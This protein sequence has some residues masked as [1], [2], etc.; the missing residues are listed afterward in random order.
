MQLS[1][2]TAVSP[3]DGRYGGKTSALRPIFS[4][5]GL[6]RCRVQVEVRWLQR[7]AAHAGIPEVA[8]FSDEANALLDQ[9]AENFQLEHAERVKEFE[10]TTNHDVKAVEYLLKEQ[11]KQLPELAK[12]NEFIHFAC[13]SEDINNLSHALMLR[14]GRD[15]VLLPLM[16]QLADAIRAL[17][18]AYAD[19]PMLSRTHGQ[20]ASPTTLGKELANVVYRLERQI[21]QVAAVPLLGK[22]NG[23]VGNYNAHLSAYPNVDWEANAREFIEG[24][25]GLSWNPYTT[26]IEPHDYIAELFDAV[27]RFNTILIDFDRDIWGYISLG[28]FKQRTVA[29]EIG[30]STMPHKVNPIDF[31][32][33]E[34]NLGIANAL[35]SHLAS[36]LPISRWQRDLTDSTVLRNL[37]V[38]FAHSIIAYE[39]S[40]KG[41]GKLEL[42]E[43]RIA[44]DLDACWEVLA[45]PIQTVMRR[46][47]IENPYEKLKEL[48]RGK[49]IS[50]EAL[51]TFIDGLDM[52][53]EAKQELRKLTPAAYIGNAIEQAKRI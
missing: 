18:V 47:A 28:Y 46:Y 53:A 36:K 12:V 11:A 21:A 14:E 45:E 26:Q 22:I 42:N 16:R 1:S 6:I 35:L 2:L 24:D 49:G 15:E 33:S 43:A 7:L 10:R 39:A 34:G 4:E 25:L 5:F 27:A 9:L 38:G 37:G 41:I 19:V 40:L 30:S 32:N 8:P 29:G 31:E 20:P 50:P 23:A 51:Q 17:A 52:P 48:T 44:Q 13:T 3:V